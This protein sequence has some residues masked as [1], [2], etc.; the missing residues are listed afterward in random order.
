MPS[1][2]PE[3]E[4]IEKK[5]RTSARR[6]KVGGDTT[7]S[8]DPKGTA[9]KSLPHPLGGCLYHAIKRQKVSVE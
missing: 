5:D 8:F 1:H 3:V 4:D 7:T 6:M 9:A 2:R